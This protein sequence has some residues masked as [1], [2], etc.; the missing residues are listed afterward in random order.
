MTFKTGDKVF[1]YLKDNGEMLCGFDA[2]QPCPPKLNPKNK[3]E[4]VIGPPYCSRKWNPYIVVFLASNLEIFG[5]FYDYDKT[6]PYY[7][8]LINHDKVD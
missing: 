5:L 2:L 3:V 4:G 1:V 6:R 7:P 8:V